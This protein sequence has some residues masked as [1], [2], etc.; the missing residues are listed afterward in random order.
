MAM[1]IWWQ[2]YSGKG[3][4]RS[5]RRRQWSAVGEEDRWVVILKSLDED[6]G[7][8]KAV[9]RKNWDSDR[10]LWKTTTRGRQRREKINTVT[11]SGAK[12]LG[13]ARQGGKGYKAGWRRKTRDGLRKEAEESLQVEDKDLCS[14]RVFAGWKRW[15]WF[16][17]RVTKTR[18]LGLGW[19]ALI[20]CQ[21]R[22][23]EE[24]KRAMV[25]DSPLKYIYRCKKS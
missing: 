5:Q 12:I 17:F 6:G 19:V 13:D 21:C 9:A 14:C 22:D 2:C 23:L 25:W 16:F 7:G 11:K 1:K 15:T 24:R 20:P 3:D 4:D 8:R 18:V 10:S